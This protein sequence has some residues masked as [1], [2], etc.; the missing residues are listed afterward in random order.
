[1]ALGAYGAHALKPTGPD[2]DYYV[3]TFDRA[4]RY[5]LTHSLLIAAAPLARCALLWL[6]PHCVAA[7]PAASTVLMSP[8]ELSTRC[9]SVAGARALWVVW[10]HWELSCSPAGQSL[11][12]F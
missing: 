1:V 9:R 7:K 6:L 4:S 5:H 10:P 8:H 12:F 3:S 11:T 2:A